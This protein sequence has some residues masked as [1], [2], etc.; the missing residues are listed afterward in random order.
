M[1]RRQKFALVTGCGKGGIGEAIIQEYTRHGVHTIA[2]VLPNENSDH[3]V[4]VGA[5]WFPLD[6]TDEESVANLKEKILV[7]TNGYLDFLVNNAGI[8]YTMTAIDTDV[9]AVK[10]MFEVNVFG[11][12]QMVHHFH[13]M[14]IRATGTI[15]NIGSI[16]GVVPYMYGASYNASK[17]ALHHYSNTLRLEMSPFNVKVLTVIS[18]EVGTNILKNDVHRKLPPGSY[19]SPLEAEFKDHVQRTPKFEVISSPMALDWK[20]HWHY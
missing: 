6:V 11:P 9:N 14:L 2:T 5:T 10:R 20:C 12:M 4:A 16:G 18:G 15:V 1:A 19:Y 7:L 8:C 13:D 3:L 17:A